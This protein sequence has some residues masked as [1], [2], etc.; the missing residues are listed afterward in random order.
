MRF[1]T[2]T[3]IYQQIQ[4]LRFFAANHLRKYNLCLNGRY[5]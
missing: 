4:Y 3:L 5:Y 1:Y 2:F